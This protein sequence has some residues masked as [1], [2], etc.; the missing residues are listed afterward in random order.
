MFEGPLFSTER[1]DVS[2]DCCKVKASTPRWNEDRSPISSELVN[3]IRFLKSFS[4]E[5]LE[6]IIL[7]KVLPPLDM[8]PSV[9]S[10]S[11]LRIGG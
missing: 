4:S 1:A 5:L 7:F 10:L 11:I 9:R 2:L 6:E 8:G 3:F